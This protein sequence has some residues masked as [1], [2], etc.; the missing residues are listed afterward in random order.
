[1]SYTSYANVRVATMSLWVPLLGLWTAQV[2]MATGDTL[3][4]TGTLQHGNLSLAGAVYRQA[5]IGGQTTAL[6]VGGFGGWGK[7]VVP[8]GYNSPFGVFLSTVVN[9]AAVECGE[10][11][12][13]VTD[14]V[15][16]T[17]WARPTTRQGVCQGGD[18][19]RSAAGSLW[20]IN[21]AGVVQVGPRT[22]TAI[23]SDFTVID[24]DGGAGVL[25]VATEDIA[26]WTP[27]NTF[28][29]AFVSPTQTVAAVRHIVD[30]DGMG[31]TRVVVT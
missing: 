1:M 10:Q 8:R 24:W 25:T 7:A 28:S 12:A 4:S 19:L 15:V 2:G 14:R 9:D 27:S 31:R 3:P 21:S 5:T 13:V 23:T 30:H 20:W 29:S 16:G 22:G 17:F 11:V 18:V 26:S 6:L